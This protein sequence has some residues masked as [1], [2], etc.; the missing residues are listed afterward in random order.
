MAELIFWIFAPLLWIG[1]AC[2]WRQIY[3]DISV[4][5]AD[6]I[7]GAIMMAVSGCI[8]FFGTLGTANAIWGAA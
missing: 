1:C 6:P 8:V 7:F 2:F 3:R 5:N 4:G